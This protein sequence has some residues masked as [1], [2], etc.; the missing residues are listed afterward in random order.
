MDNKKKLTDDELEKVAGGY[1]PDMFYEKKGR[2][3][4]TSRRSLR[5]GYRKI[6][7]MI[8]RHLVRNMQNSRFSRLIQTPRF[9][10]I[11]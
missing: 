11:M 4:L 1:N 2:K 9:C 3:L 6:N 5:H 10:R 7:L 8:F